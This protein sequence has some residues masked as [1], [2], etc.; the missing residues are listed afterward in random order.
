MDKNAGLFGMVFERLMY[1]ISENIW[2]Y[3]LD[4]VYTGIFARPPAP[5]AV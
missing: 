4:A 2:V 3:I 1:R 5:I